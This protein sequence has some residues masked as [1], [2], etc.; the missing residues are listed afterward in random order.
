MQISG[1]TCSVDTVSRRKGT[2]YIKAHELFNP[3]VTFKITM[4]ADALILVPFGGKASDT[5]RIH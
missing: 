2:V 4:P 5:E 1:V 3:N